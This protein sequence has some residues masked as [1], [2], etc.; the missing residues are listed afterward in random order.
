[1]KDFKFL[2]T[3][4]TPESEALTEYQ[5][6]NLESGPTTIKIGVP[7]ANVEAFDAFISEQPDKISSIQDNLEAYNLII[8][9]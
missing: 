5:V 4:A 1:M 2:Q 8:L 7:L 9:D 6:Y 3:L